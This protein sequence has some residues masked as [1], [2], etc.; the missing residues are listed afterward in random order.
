I[1]PQFQAT[2]RGKRSLGLDLKHPEGRKLLSRLAASAA[3]LVPT[4]RPA[5]IRNLRIDVDDVRADNPSIIYVR[6]TAFG[7]RG[8]DGGRGGDDSGPYG[9]RSGMQQ[10]FPRPGDEWPASPRPAFGDVVGGLSI[11]GAIGTAL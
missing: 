1:D 4:L 7:S 2:N 8:P 10:I 5:A 3:V 6:G 9:A 11:A